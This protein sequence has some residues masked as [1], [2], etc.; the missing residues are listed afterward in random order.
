MFGWIKV[1][2]HCTYMYYEVDDNQQAESHEVYFSDDDVYEDLD[3]I[4]D[5]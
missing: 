3:L 2:T 1:E 4:E 5:E